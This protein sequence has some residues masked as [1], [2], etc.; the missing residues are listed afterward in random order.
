MTERSGTSRACAPRALP[1][2]VPGATCH[3]GRVPTA[4]IPPPP[5][6]PRQLWLDP[7]SFHT[8]SLGPLRLSTVS[9]PTPVTSGW[10]AGSSTA[11]PTSGGPSCGDCSTQSEEPLSPEAANTVW[12][13][14]AI[15]SRIGASAAWSLKA[16]QIPHEVL[17]TW[18]VSSV[19]IRWRVSIGPVTLFGPS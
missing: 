7:Q 8:D 12:P 14:A 2:G 9:P 4:E 19:A 13:W 10:E 15:C 1:V 3:A 5:A 16:S 6:L 18:A 11:A 17:T